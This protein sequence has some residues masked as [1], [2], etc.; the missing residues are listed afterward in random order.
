MRMDPTQL[1]QILVN[2]CVNARDAISGVGKISI[3]TDTAVF[4]E[5]YC[6]THADF[7]PGDFVMLSVSD[8]G[9]GMDRATMDKI[10]EPFF[11]TKELGRGTGLGL[12]TVY[13]IVRQN[14]GFVNVYSE[15]GRGTAF[16]IYL[17]RHDIP[18]K[19]VRRKDSPASEERGS[20]TIL[21]VEDDDMILRMTAMML[22]RLGYKV[23]AAGSPEEAIDLAVENA[24][25]IHL[26][27]T[28]VVMPD[29]NGRDLADRIQSLCPGIKILFMSG[30]T[31]D[32]IAHRGVLDKG[33]NFIHKPFTKQALAVKI[34]EVLKKI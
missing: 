18:E 27:I 29:M 7:V 23:L 31:A 11:T 10:F 14:S 15:P 17:P 9:C 33:V 2:L 8:D 19:K 12:A 16:R 21:L 34:R 25:R 22:E 13:G 26:L 20:E 32:V 4:D 28:D 6:S 5:D 1:D 30:Y 24:G 3:E